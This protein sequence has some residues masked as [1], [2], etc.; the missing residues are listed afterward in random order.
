MVEPRAL[1]TDHPHRH[2]AGRGGCRLPA[3]GGAGR[4]HRRDAGPAVGGGPAARDRRPR[5]RR[6]PRSPRDPRPRRPAYRFA[7]RA[8]RKRGGPGLPDQAPAGD[9][10]PA[11]GARPVGHRGVGRRR[12]QGLGRAAV[13]GL[14]AEHRDHLERLR[15][16]G[17][18]AAWRD[19]GQAG[20][21]RPKGRRAVRRR[22]LPDEQPGA[23]DRQADRRKRHGRDL[24]R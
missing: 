6:A 11:T 20:P 22:R 17:H 7:R 5:R 23:G 13:P 9:R 18:L 1:E 19:R 15:G 3:G 14:R 10:R 16:D 4:R 21:P 8:R 12:P 2:H 24:A